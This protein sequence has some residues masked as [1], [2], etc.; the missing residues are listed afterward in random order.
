MKNITLIG[1][2]NVA[3]HLGLSLIKKGFKIKQVWSRTRDNAEILAKKLHSSATDSINNLEN[4]DLYILAIKDD[5]LESIIQQLDQETNII[6]VSGSINIEIF[7]KKFKHYG[8][9]Y[10]L[11]T[12]NKEVT[13]DFSAIPIFIE[14]NTSKFQN[15]LLNMGN[16]LSNTV[17]IMNS[18]KRKKLHVSAVF[19]CNFT[20][21]MFSIADAILHKENIDFQLLLPLINQTVK[22]LNQSS[23][24]ELQTGPAIRKDRKLI[25]EHINSITDKETQDLYKL[26]SNSIMKK[27]K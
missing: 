5:Y 23:P 13:I 27:N 18:E 9:L 15:Q 8:V 19:A 17:V 14:A 7:N 26:I 22:K 3:T 24:A 2:G 4:S 16:K 6:H 10:P 12:F 20:T 25:K 11:Q 1:S 21:H